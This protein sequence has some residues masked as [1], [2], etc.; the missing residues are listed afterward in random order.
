MDDFGFCVGESGERVGGVVRGALMG[1][2]MRQR[3]FLLGPHHTPPVSM[4]ECVCGQRR[5]CAATLVLMP[6]SK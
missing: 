3:D 6:T 1:M 4:V 2:F 5:Y